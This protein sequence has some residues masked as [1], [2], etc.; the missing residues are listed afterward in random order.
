MQFNSISITVDHHDEPKYHMPAPHN[1]NGWFTL[2]DM[3]TLGL[4]NDT[5]SALEYLME[6]AR[7]IN[8]A[9]TAISNAQLSAICDLTQ[10]H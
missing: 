5:Q 8:D 10:N 9:R 3:T 4:P 1:V 2:G 7:A 6:L